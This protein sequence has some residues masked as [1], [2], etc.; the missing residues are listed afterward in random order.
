MDTA[1]VTHILAVHAHPDDIEFLAAGTLALLTAMSHRVTIATLTA[2]DCGSVETNAEETARVRQR[3]AAASAAVI[4][5]AYVCA[6]FRDLAVFNDDPSR[7]RVV[8]LIRSVRPDIVITASPQD[9][10]PDHEATSI[11]VR[12]SCFAASVPNYEAGTAEPLASIP[13]LYFM[14]P[15]DGRDRDGHDIAPEFGV[16][17]EAYFETKLQM[18]CAHA[19]QRNWVLKQHS[20]DDY[21]G[22]MRAWTEKRG[23][24][25]GV[26]HAEG[27]RQYKCH[28]YPVTPLMQELVGDALLAGYFA[29]AGALR[30][31]S[32]QR[33]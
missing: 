14:D 33:Q 26:S 20:I 9:Y 11:L 2:G 7:R 4:G 24:R 6:E 19:S 17:V 15:I 25:F 28:P 29:R 30:E 10:H 23:R 13:H 5:A 22:S 3:E 31:E 16:D 32:P 8:G 27:F 12:D 1:I 18:L 21:L